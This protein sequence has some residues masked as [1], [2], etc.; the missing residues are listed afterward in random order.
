MT[1]WVDWNQDGDFDDP[2]ETFEFGDPGMPIGSGQITP[3]AGATLGETRMRVTVQYQGPP[4]PCATF[5]VG[6]VE[7][8]TIN[9]VE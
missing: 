6:E 7:D 2:D 8:Y 4:D 9:V 3:P 1:A 5:S